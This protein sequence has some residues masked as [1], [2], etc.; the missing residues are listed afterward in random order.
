MTDR[1]FEKLLRSAFGWCVIFFV[2]LAIS[3]FMGWKK[4]FVALQIPCVVWCGIGLALYTLWI[5]LY[6]LKRLRG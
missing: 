6:G 3:G 1:D 4:A 2:L 5:V